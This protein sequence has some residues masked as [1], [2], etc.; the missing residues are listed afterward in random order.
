MATV[1]IAIL[2]MV[3][4]LRPALVAASARSA[5]D[6]KTDYS[7]VQRALAQGHDGKSWRQGDP[8]LRDLLDKAWPLMGEWAVAYL[9]RDANAKAE[10]LVAT[11]GELNPTRAPTPSGGVGEPRVPDDVGRGGG[12]A[13]GVFVEPDTSDAFF[14]ELFRASEFPPVEHMATCEPDC[15]PHRPS[16]ANEGVGF[17]PSIGRFRDVKGYTDRSQPTRGV[18]GAAP[19]RLERLAAA[20]ARGKPSR[21]NVL[22]AKRAPCAKLVVNVHAPD[23]HRGWTVGSLRDVGDAV[24]TYQPLAKRRR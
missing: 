13:F 12:W 2:L 21:V 8:T 22:D 14:Q 23:S 11:I 16:R 4:A 20:A 15:R 1:L 9:G 10:K 5:A 6:I 7:E 3:D 24:P 19:G 17:D 18:P